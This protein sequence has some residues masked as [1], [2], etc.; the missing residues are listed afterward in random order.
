[1]CIR[2]RRILDSLIM[3]LIAYS[4]MKLFST[5]ISKK[6]SYLICAL[7]LLYPFI[8]MS[9]AG[10]ISTTA[11]YTWP[12]ALG[13]YGMTYLRHIYDKTRV[14]WWQ[15]ILFCLSFILSLIHISL[16]VFLYKFKIK[17]SCFL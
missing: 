17:E 15:H 1:M 2:D 6:T 11:N 12:L 3:V 5:T 9:S 14:Y 4:I 7:V 13:L 10:W 8:Q 16:I